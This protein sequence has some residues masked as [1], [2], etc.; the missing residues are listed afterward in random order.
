MKVENVKAGL[1]KLLP[2]LE[3][4]EA[5]KV[6][7]DFQKLVELMDGYEDMTID[8]FCKKAREGLEGRKKSAGGAASLRQ[9]VVDAH[10]EALK[11][12]NENDD[13]FSSAIDAIAS[14]KQVRMK[15]LKAIAEGYM[16]LTPL[17]KKKN[18]LLDEM[19]TL[20]AQNFRT[21]HKL[22]ILSKW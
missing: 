6:S 18:D 17:A 12:T 16:M 11:T 9:A 20:R 10:V 4:W 3:T 5:T 21:D 7:K 14:D 15:E 2:V 1:E 19:K 8:A 22:K 13:Q